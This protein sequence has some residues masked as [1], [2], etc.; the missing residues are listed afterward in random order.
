MHLF[1]S[2]VRVLDADRVPQ[3]GPVLVVSN[4]HSALIDPAVLIATLPRQPRFLAKAVLWEP[5]YSLLRPFLVLARAVPVHRAKDGGGSNDDMFSETRAALQAG[6]MIALFGEGVSHDNAGLLDLK[7]GAARIARGTSSAVAVLPVGIIYPDRT[8]YRST[9]T[10]AVGEVI[11]VEGVAGGDID[12]QSVR[13][14]T[15]RIRA[16]LAA[17]APTWESEDKHQAAVVAAEIAAARFGT[18]AATAL[19]SLNRSVDRSESHALTALDAARDLLDECQHLGVAVA[20]VIDFTPPQLKRMERVSR[21]KTA[22]WAVP[23]VVG[24]VLTLPAFEL[25]GKL[26]DRRDVNFQATSKLALG[27]VIYP[28]WWVVLALAFG[29]IFSPLMGLAVAIVAPV[30]AYIS[31][32]KMHRL[33]RFTTARLGGPASEAQLGTLHARHATVVEAMREV[34]PAKAR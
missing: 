29:S 27:L 6:E 15:D 22:A 32:L 9:V 7:T 19:S 5:R 14:L 28:I 10:V 34:I 18:D 25:T 16:G 3:D 31:A 4:H 1:F 11:E 12:R 26:S 24:K 17:V 30:T 13:E 23:T 8:T 2:E 21:V 20:S 33:R